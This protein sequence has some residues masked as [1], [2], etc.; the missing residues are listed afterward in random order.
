M[1]CHIYLLFSQ[2]LPTSCLPTTM[3]YYYYRGSI[4]DPVR[5]LRLSS[6]VPPPASLSHRPEVP[7]I[8][9]TEYRVLYNIQSHVNPWTDNI[10]GGGVVVCHGEEDEDGL[11]NIYIVCLEL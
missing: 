9:T 2:T 11:V 4:P 8:P 10:G 7:T 5:L 3:N 1:L 6:T